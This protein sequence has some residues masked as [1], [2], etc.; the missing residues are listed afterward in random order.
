MEDIAIFGVIA[1]IGVFSI[2]ALKLLRGPVGSK[3][4]IK[5]AKN[6]SIKDLIESKDHTITTYKKELQMLNG[7][8]ARFR[9]VED[10]V[11]EIPQKQV[12]FEEITALANQRFP[13]NKYIKL[14]PLFEDQIMEKTKG[15]SLEQI[16]QFAEQITG[17]QEPK[18]SPLPNASIY[19]PD[20]A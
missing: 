8:L 1:L 18:G 16:L 4:G 11:E 17:N 7:K 20:W 3:K 15:M 6:D 19:N 10:E 12:S 9:Q 5:E 2:I 14:L 13:N